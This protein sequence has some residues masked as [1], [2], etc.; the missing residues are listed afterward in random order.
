MQENVV[1]F[2][3]S[4]LMHF[5][6]GLYDGDEVVLNSTHFGM[7]GTRTRT[8]RCSSHP[9]SIVHHPSAPQPPNHSCPDPRPYDLSISHDKRPCPF[10]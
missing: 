8:A 3:M 2:P 6:G 5:L 7:P 9:S 10:V 1:R 4:H